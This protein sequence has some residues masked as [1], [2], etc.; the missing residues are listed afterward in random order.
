MPC[1]GM[2]CHV[3]PCH[4]MSCHAMPC[5]V[6]SCHVMSCH[7]MSCHAMSDYA[8]H[9][10]FRL[11]LAQLCAPSQSLQA[12]RGPLP[13]GPPRHIGDRH[14]G[15]ADQPRTRRARLAQERPR[16]TQASP[17]GR[18]VKACREPEDQTAL[19][20]IQRA[21]GVI[22]TWQ[23][24][25]QKGPLR[26]CSAGERRTKHVQAFFCTTNGYTRTRIQTHTHAEKRIVSPSNSA[27]RGTKV[28][29]FLF[30]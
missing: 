23:A 8:T 2:S 1:H 11:R 16:G 19:K 5:H 13:E 7:V 20:I 9:E 4:V 10:A 12:Q 24:G 29:A 18:P 3:M 17:Q 21:Q 28:F 30:G 25:E 26:Q 27:S 14:G 22:G 15:T 6:M